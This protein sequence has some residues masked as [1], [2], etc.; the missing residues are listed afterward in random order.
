MTWC[1]KASQS[2]PKDKRQH[3]FNQ[4]IGIFFQ[5]IHLKM[6]SAKWRPPFP[7]DRNALIN[8]NANVRHQVHAG[9][10]EVISV[11]S[12]NIPKILSVMYHLSVFITPGN[13]SNGQ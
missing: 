4:N 6:S 8:D 11:C 9:L 2:D 1:L 3:F 5:E 7:S 10:R 12:V 13:M